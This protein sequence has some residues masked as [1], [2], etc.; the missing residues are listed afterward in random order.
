M[1]PGALLTA[2]AQAAEASGGPACFLGPRDHAPKSGAFHLTSQSDLDSCR[3]LLLLGF[4]TKSQP[5]KGGV[6]STKTPVFF[7]LVQHMF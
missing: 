2:A 1:A 4:P 6:S 3:F 5:K 7:H